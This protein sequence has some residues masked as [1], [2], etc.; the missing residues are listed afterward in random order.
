MGNDVARECI[1][2]GFQSRLK[3]HAA[4]DPVRAKC[5]HYHG[6]TATGFAVVQRNFERWVRQKIL[7]NLHGQLGQDSFDSLRQTWQVGEWQQ[8][9][10][11]DDGPRESA[12]HEQQNVL[13]RSKRV[14]DEAH[15]SANRHLAGSDREDR[16]GGV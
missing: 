6:S 5:R 16:L 3:H 11:K 7:L 4:A 2:L 12:M 15:R 13:Y 8:V 9:I 10:A 1:G 14:V